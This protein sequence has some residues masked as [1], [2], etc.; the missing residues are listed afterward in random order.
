MSYTIIPQSVDIEALPDNEAIILN[1]EDKLTFGGLFY[2]F[3]SENKVDILRL[4]AENSLSYNDYEGSFSNIFIDSDLNYFTAWE[5]ADNTILNEDNDERTTTE[6][7]FQDVLTISDINEFVTY[8]RSELYTAGNFVGMRLRLKITYE[9]DTEIITEEVSHQNNTWVGRNIVNPF[10]S[11]K[12]KTVVYQIRRTSGS[13]VLVRIRNNTIRVFENVIF[14]LPLSAVDRVQLYTT[15]GVLV[16]DNV[17]IV[18]E[19]DTE[20][21]LNSFESIE[22]NGDI[23]EIKLNIAM[24]D[25]VLFYW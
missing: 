7:T 17:F 11:K 14:N 3:V 24:S 19:N 20:I 23:K 10:I 18:L 13:S 4:M 6:T 12:I 25:F 22:I 1:F 16:P 2:K 9:D 15:S 5:S 21:P 8:F